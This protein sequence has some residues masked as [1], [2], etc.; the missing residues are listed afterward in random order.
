MRDIVLLLLMVSCR[1]KERYSLWRK[2][3]RQK[4]EEQHDVTLDEIQDVFGLRVIV[5]MDRGEGENLEAWRQRGIFHCYR[6][7]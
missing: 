6:L 3:E 7:N 1:L 5:S 4:L 2:M